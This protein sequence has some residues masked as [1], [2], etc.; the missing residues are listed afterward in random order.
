MRP[1]DKMIF[2]AAARALNLWILVRRTNTESLKYI[3]KPGYVPKRI[4]CKAKTAD[5]NIGK[6]E[7]AGLVVDPDIH[8]KA[9]KPG[10]LA[11]AMQAWKSMEGHMGTYEVESSTTSKHFGC[12][13]IHGQYIHGDYDLYD[14]IDPKQPHRNL[15]L[16][17]ESYG[18]MHV[19]GAN[20]QKV[21]NYINPKIGSAMIQHGGEAQYA[22][23]SEQSIDVFGPG[24]EDYT[25]LN[26]FSL[27]AIYEARFKGRQHIVMPKV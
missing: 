19:I 1:Q 3:T 21:M 2:L 14:I 27:K 11:K 24:G 23:L 6:F 9:F 20:T 10:K 8:P 16:V 13:K 5:F 17:S 18:M 15:A 26:A 4:D 25:V 12:L 22:D 7:L